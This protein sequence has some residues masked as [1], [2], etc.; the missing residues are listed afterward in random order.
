MISKD[1]G[2]TWDRAGKGVRRSPTIK[3]NIM[4]PNRLSIRIPPL[5]YSLSPKIGKN[6]SDFLGSIKD[7]RLFNQAKDMAEKL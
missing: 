4:N 6:V 3:K 2:K 5:S 1:G 7:G